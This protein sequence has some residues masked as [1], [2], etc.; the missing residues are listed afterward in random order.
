MPNKK[1][2][3][4]KG[5]KDL[6]TLPDA[7]SNLIVCKAEPFESDQGEQT[8]SGYVRTFVIS[9]SAIDREGDRIL[10]EGW[11]LENYR[12]GGTVLYAHNSHGLPVGFPEKTWVESGK[13]RQRIRFATRDEGEF[14]WSIGKLVEAGILRA[15]SVGFQPI[16]WAFVEDRPG[17]MPTDFIRQELLE[18]SIVPVPANPE[19]L[20]EAKGMGIDGC[21]T[22]GYGELLD[23]GDLVTI[24]RD[25]LE[26]AWKMVRSEVVVSV[27]SATQEDK[28][29]ISF[30]SAH[31]S[32]T[33][34]AAESADWDAGKEV[35]AADVDDLKVMCTWVDSED[36][37]NKGAYKLPHHKA[38]GEH[39]VVWKGVSAAMAALL[40][41]RGG[42]DLPDGDRKGVYNHLK[43]HYAEF[44]KEPPDFKEAKEID[45]DRVDLLSERITQLA[46]QVGALAAMLEDQEDAIEIEDESN[47]VDLLDE[48]DPQDVAD[49][50]HEAAVDFVNKQLRRLS[51][52]LD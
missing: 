16:E 7:P 8:A 27:P 35:A 47:G 39:A 42:V 13:L 31:S 2:V 22:K 9:T 25:V 4:I 41:S 33:P 36:K 37:E 11:D 12:K 1:R 50:V 21:L 24:E 19:A 52:R 44:G 10:A 38:A 23:L 18:N 15:A 20:A 26:A 46:N 34:K 43:K 17:L 14:G 45:P 28:G 6:A 49:A 5:F 40:G 51:G 29:A 48:I 30:A 32:G 3:T